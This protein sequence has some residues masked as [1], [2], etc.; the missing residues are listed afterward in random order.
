MGEYDPRAARR[1]LPLAI[2]ALD[3]LAACRLARVGGMHHA[4]LVIG[5][6][7]KPGAPCGKMPRCIALPV[8]VLAPHLGDLDP[9]VPLMDRAEGGP[10]LDRL[11]LLLIADQHDLCACM[12]GMGEHAL[13]LARADH[14]S[15]VDHQHIACGEQLAALVPLVLQAGN[16]ARRNA[17]AILQTLGGNAGQGGPANS[18]A[19]VFPGLARHAEHRALAGPGMT[20]DDAETALVGHMLERRTLL[21]G[22]DKATLRRARQRRVAA[23]LTDRILSALSH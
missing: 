17:R 12:G 18:V 10:C 20:D 9:A 13:H 5:C 22:E 23:T 1:I 8:V 3:Q 21:A 19:R 4:A 14:A 2:P 11:Q 7:R 16:G 6:N 15:L